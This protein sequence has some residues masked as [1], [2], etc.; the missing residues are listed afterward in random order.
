MK[1]AQAEG[2][3]AFHE[4]GNVDETDIHELKYF[5]SIIKLT[6]DEWFIKRKKEFSM[7]NK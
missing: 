6:M 5:E 2:G 4:K 7:H 3:N 1:R